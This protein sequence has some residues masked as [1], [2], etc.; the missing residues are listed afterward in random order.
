MKKK[1]LLFSL[2]M[3]L[4]LFLIGCGD[5]ENKDKDKD[6]DNDVKN[7]TQENA[8]ADK[9]EK[10]YESLNGKEN[11]YGTKYREIS[12]DDS[13]PIVYITA[14]E[15]VEKIDAKESFYVYFGSNK[16]PWCRSV[17]EKAL[18]MAEFNDVSK[19][20]YVDIWDEDGNEILRDKY[21]IDE[22]GKLVQTIKGTDAY[23]DLLERFD[24]VLEKYTLTDSNGKTVHTK[25]K[26]IF[27][28]NFIYVSNGEAK[29]LVTGISK[30]Q[31][32]SNAKLTDEIL[33]DEEAVFNEFFATHLTCSDTLC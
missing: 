32:N 12:I 5:D 7:K 26:R 8:D 11:S 23:Y 20:Y 25:E 14:E 17:I 10:E 22:K 21:E 19:I 13:N 15:V 29:A 3:T 1:L 30:K 9:F 4:S 2:L 6:K 18:A 28:P 31:T 33:E 16:C 27:A 24:N